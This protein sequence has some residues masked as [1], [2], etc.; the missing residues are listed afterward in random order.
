MCEPCS[1]IT[2]ARPSG[3]KTSSIIWTFDAA[4]IERPM[5]SPVVDLLADLAAALRAL[6]V[7]WFLSA[8]WRLSLR[9]LVR[10]LRGMVVDVWQAEDVA[11]PEWAAWYR[12][13]PR[14]RWLETERLWLTFVALGGSLDPEPDT[15]SP[16]FD[17]RAPRAR[18]PHGGS[19]VR[20]IRRRGI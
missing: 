13:T 12:L 16:F 6:E 11:G 14:Q 4:S 9:N 18:A 17:R 2:H 10:S 15:H 5:P 3:G 8:R 20:D 7:P 19:G 1:A